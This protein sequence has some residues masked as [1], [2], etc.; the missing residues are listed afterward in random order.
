MQNTI[1]TARTTPI[2]TSL[3]LVNETRTCGFGFVGDDRIGTDAS[4]AAR[5]RA[6]YPNHSNARVSAVFG[7]H[8]RF[9]NSRSVS[10][11]S[12]IE[13][14]DERAASAVPLLLSSCN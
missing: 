13:D 1:G 2:Q 8:L 10:Q 6:D 5:V 14:K 7:R 9:A 4:A 3:M 12:P 11:A